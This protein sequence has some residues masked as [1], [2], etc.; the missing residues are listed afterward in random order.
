MPFGSRPGNPR[1]VQGQVNPNAGGSSFW[2]KVLTENPAAPNLGQRSPVAPPPSSVPT[3]GDGSLAVDTGIQDRGNAPMMEN[4]DPQIGEVYPQ[5][6]DRL[7]PLPVQPVRP[8]SPGGTG[9]AMPVALEAGLYP[10]NNAIGPQPS[11]LDAG[12][13]VTAPPPP[14]PPPD[15]GLLL[16]IYNRLRGMGGRPHPSMRRGT[17]Q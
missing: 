9:S 17:V 14:P 16:M 8:Q 6:P 5:T 7:S 12:R 13:N 11:P 1:N 2:D 15:P 3:R 4:Y 10:T